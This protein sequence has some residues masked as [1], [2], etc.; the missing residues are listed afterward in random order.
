MKRGQ[1]IE[2]LGLGKEFAVFEF[3]SRCKMEVKCSMTNLIK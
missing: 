1:R 3:Y 2:H